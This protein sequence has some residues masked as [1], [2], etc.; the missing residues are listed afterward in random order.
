MGRKCALAN[1]WHGGGKGVIWREDSHDY[2]N[3]LFFLR[4]IELSYFISLL[5]IFLLIN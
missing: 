3:R 2:M 4:I 5:Y 1:L